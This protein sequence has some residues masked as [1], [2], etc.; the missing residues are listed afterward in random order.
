LLS[1]ITGLLGGEAQ[2]YRD[3]RQVPPADGGC[4]PDLFPSGQCSMAEPV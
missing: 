1:Q 2:R 4:G 3:D